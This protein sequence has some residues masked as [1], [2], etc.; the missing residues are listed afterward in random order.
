MTPSTIGNSQIDPP[1]PGGKVST[2]IDA[3]DALGPG[4]GCAVDDVAATAVA[5]EHD[6][7]G[8]RVDLVDDGVDPVGD[9]DLGGLVRRRADA[10]HRERVDG[11]AGALAARE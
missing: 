9:A 10:R 4:V 3:G 5:D 1:S 11:M 2:K 8:K 7:A 6:E